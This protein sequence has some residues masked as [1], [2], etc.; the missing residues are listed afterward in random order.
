MKAPQLLD[1]EP[2]GA[3]FIQLLR[4]RIHGAS[5]N[6]ALSKLSEEKDDQNIT[7]NE[8]AEEETDLSY[9]DEVTPELMH[10]DLA[11]WKKH[12]HY[13]IIG[14]PK[15][16][17]AAT[18]AQI[19]NAYRRRVLKY[20]PDKKAQS[21]NATSGKPKNPDDDHFF[22]CVQKSYELLSDPV[23]RRQYDSVDSYYSDEIPDRNDKSEFFSLYG[24][25]FERE[26]RFS[27]KQPVPLLGDDNTPQEEVEQFYNFWYNFDS[28]R[29]FEFLDKEDLESAENREEKRWLE[30]QNRDE[31]QR[32]KREDMARIRRRVDQAFKRDPRIKR[33]KELQKQEL[34][35]KKQAK[36]QAA[37]LAREDE[38]RA[39][40][41]AQRA[42]EKAEQEERERAAA[43]KKQRE[44]LKS[45]L[46]KGRK[47]VK[48]LLKVN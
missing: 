22:K 24:P 33:F 7:T 35:A 10:L 11:D 26:A 1:I 27:K 42:K 5:L 6:D 45:K 8:N 30:R 43:E 13:A 3:T 34:E 32:R 16:R 40:L 2:V 29:S 37:R 20:H 28:W 4:Y 15:L 12:D 44:A 18:D 17:W 39:R 25:V 14:L 9:D 19:R 46:R 48:A 31:R 47:A 38:E 41:E 23:R 36:E 21:D